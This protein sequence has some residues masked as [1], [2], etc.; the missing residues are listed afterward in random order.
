MRRLCFLLIALLLAG[1]V[2]APFASVNPNDR[3]WPGTM[4]LTLS[5][6]TVWAAEPV[7][8]AQVL[9]DPVV[10]GYTPLWGLAGDLIVH[11][12]DGVFRVTRPVLTVTPVQIT[13]RF[14]GATAT[15]IVYVVPDPA[16]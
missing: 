3:E 13:A 10:N 1:C 12:G 4:S 7:F 2:D 15:R 11:E 9:T 6:D 14:A 16:P 8:V 5:R